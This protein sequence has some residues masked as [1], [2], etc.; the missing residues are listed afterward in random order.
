[1]WKM[2]DAADPRNDRSVLDAGFLAG[3]VGAAFAAIFMVVVP[4]LF[5]VI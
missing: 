2:L 1:M 5:D 4:L 3:L